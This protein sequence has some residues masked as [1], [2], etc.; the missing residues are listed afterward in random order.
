M[1]L[2]QHLYIIQI[3]VRKNRNETDGKF[4]EKDITDC[5]TTEYRE[6]IERSS[7]KT[8]T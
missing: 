8:Q 2:N 4:S 7:K 3:Q 5:R 6:L 1:G